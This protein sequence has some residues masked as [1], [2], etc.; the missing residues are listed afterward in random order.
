MILKFSDQPL[1][2]DSRLVNPFTFRLFEGQ[3]CIFPDH[4]LTVGCSILLLTPTLMLS[5][6]FIQGMKKTKCKISRNNTTQN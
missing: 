3:D 6:I 2:S 5:E 1:K 4:Y